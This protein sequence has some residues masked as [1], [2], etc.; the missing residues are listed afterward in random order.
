MVCASTLANIAVEPRPCQRALTPQPDQDGW[1]AGGCYAD[2]LLNF[3]L[4]QLAFGTLSRYLQHGKS[5]DLKQ[6]SPPATGP[7]QVEFLRSVVL[8][9]GGSPL[10]EFGN[11]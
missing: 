5:I 4:L 3:L 11:V 6:N 9:W 8:H 7:L 10:R 1:G 2:P